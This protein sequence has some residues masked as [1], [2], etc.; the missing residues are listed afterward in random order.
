MGMLE[1][2]GVG[3]GESEEEI[4]LSLEL[5]IGGSYAGKCEK[6]TALAEESLCKDEERGVENII[7]PRSGFSSSDHRQAIVVVESDHHRV[8]G[9][10]LRSGSSEA[11]DQN[12]NIREMQALRRRE[13]RKKREEKL[14]K[15]S[16]NCKGIINV[17]NLDK[18]CLEAQQ[19]QARAEDRA[20]KEKESVWDDHSNHCLAGTRKEK[21]VVAL[22]IDTEAMKDSNFS[23]KQGSDPKEAIAS[24]QQQNLVGVMQMP[25][26]LYQ[27]S[28]C[29][30]LKKNGSVYRYG[31]ACLG[32]SGVVAGNEEDEMMK[33]KSMFQ[34]AL[35]CGSFRPYLN[36][37]VVLNM[38]H[39]SGRGC[40]SGHNSSGGIMSRIVNQKAVS[41]GSLDRSSSAISDYRSTSGKG[42]SISDTGSHSSCLQANDRQLSLSA[43]SDALHQAEPNS[44]LSNREGG[45]ETIRVANSPK[46]MFLAAE[47]QICMVNTCGNYKPDTKSNA[48][49]PKFKDATSSPLKQSK[50]V[51]DN[52]SK[53]QSHNFAM[54]SLPQMPCVSTTGNGPNGKTITG[55]LYRYTKA[56]ISI[57]CV[58][59]GSSFSPAEFVEHAGGIDITHPLRHITM[60]PSSFR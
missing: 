43:T 42:G 2:S 16:V 13:A 59:H 3:V 57:V 37:N 36:A 56:E 32:P 35:G 34:P 60:I 49:S 7:V 53:I 30:P 24:C 22:V 25:E 45:E 55:F 33:E 11:V 17:A 39:N 48:V 58:C 5:S 44:T 41:N 29:G 4:E 38:R 20:M 10:R 15:S 6:T 1:V 26:G 54:P 50:E 28:Q 12:R 18:V 27:Q 19:L 14:R 23:E 40:D 31:V 21:N 8:E 47:P 52:P 9:G 51:K 46:Q